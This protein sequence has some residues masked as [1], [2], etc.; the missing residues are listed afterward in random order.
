VGAQLILPTV[1]T[2]IMRIT[3]SKSL[4]LLDLP[5]EIFE[6]HII[7][8]LDYPHRYALSAV[9]RFFR[10]LLRGRLFLGR[11]KEYDTPTTI[12]YDEKVF[13]SNGHWHAFGSSNDKYSRT[14][15]LL[16]WNLSQ[17]YPRLFP[18]P[19]PPPHIVGISLT[20]KYI[21]MYNI[22]T[23]SLSIHDARQNGRIVYTVDDA[24]VTPELW[25]N[26]DEHFILPHQRSATDDVSLMVHTVAPLSK[27][28]SSVPPHLCATFP[29]SFEWFKVISRTMQ[30]PWNRHAPMK[31][32]AVVIIPDLNPRGFSIQCVADNHPL[33]DTLWAVTYDFRFFVIT[34]RDTAGLF[35]YDVDNKTVVSQCECAS[36]RIEFVAASPVAYEFAVRI[37]DCVVLMV[38]LTLA[39]FSTFWTAYTIYVHSNSKA[40]H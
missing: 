7:P 39:V 37:D 15:A 31:L 21:W 38:R 20:G 3:R 10:G 13:Y 33:V 8:A 24:K 34:K 36:D 22:D 17:S 18:C 1:Q 28:A 35:V 23:Q 4:R 2:P 32:Y 5:A 29:A 11:G 12:T 6:H 25:F 16:L 40:Q 14:L 26:N 27:T 9:N 19:K 30:S